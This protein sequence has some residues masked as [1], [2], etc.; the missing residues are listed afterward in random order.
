MDN[1]VRRIAWFVSPHGKG[2]A[3]RA[4]AIMAALTKLDVS[5]HFDIYTL[6]PESFF[7]DSRIGNFTYHS[8][9][10]DLGLVQLSPY[11]EDLDAT[12]QALDT[13]IPFEDE[14]VQS[15]AAR[16]RE[17]DV[18]YVVCDIAPM[19]I[20]AA[21]VAGIRSVLIENF[22]WDW[23]YEGYLESHP[24]FSRAIDYFNKIFLEVD[25]H[26]QSKPMCDAVE[27]CLTSNVVS[28]LPRM[29]RKQTRHALGI[30]D[31][32]PLL[33]VSGGVPVDSP[34]L[35]YLAE[36][37]DVRVLIA[38]TGN[39]VTAE[40]NLTYV[41][42]DSAFFHPDLIEASDCVVGK[43]GYS[44]MAEVYW[45][46]IPFVYIGRNQF[47]ESP[48]LAAFVEDAMP[49]LA[50]TPQEFPKGE[51]VGQVCDLVSAPRISRKEP[52]GAE[53][54]ASYLCHFDK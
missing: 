12:L 2:H 33:L 18:E 52:N 26:I 24:E 40:G 50:L 8:L 9:A 3:G 37:S 29:S 54:I 47:R 42:Y 41:P 36:L 30:G 32:R 14:Q 46:G 43:L 23:I 39:R 20:A 53:E 51:W 48:Y 22:R 5:C 11:E 21:K 28:R 4:S 35:K 25:V 31:D 44:T 15:L 17:S 45:A 13:M 1:R 10:S 49:C 6:V 16:L 34:V 27:A 38:A 19:G 7:T